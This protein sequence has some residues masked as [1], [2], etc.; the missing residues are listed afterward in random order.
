VSTTDRPAEPDLDRPIKAV[1]VRHPGR[2]V[3]ALAL[4]V[5]VAML[6]NTLVSKIPSETGPGVQWR[7]GWD[8]VGRLLF[9]APY[10]SGAEMTIWL[11]FVAMSVGIAGGL[12]VAVM[13]LSPNPLLKGSAWTFT[14]FFRGTPVVIQIFFWYNIVSVYP[15][16]AIGIP[17]GHEFWQLNPNNVITPFIAAAVLGLGI[18][19]AAYMSEIYRA[20]IL[21]V[22]AGQVEAAQSLGMRRALLMRRVVLPQALRVIIPP[23][24]NEVISMLKTTSLV[25]FVGIAELL[26]Q[27]QATIAATYQVI[28]PYIAVS[29]WYLAM[30]TVLSIGQYFLE[31]HYRR[32]TTGD[33]PD[34]LARLWARMVTK[35][36]VEVFSTQGDLDALT[37]TI[38][39]HG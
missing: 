28:P 12:L 35:R 8:E 10:V 9:S 31:R 13:R 17:F 18:N 26:Y 1:P 34:G 25:A 23:T 29:L 20:G 37:P 32:G 11:T 16:L 5:I 30:T 6:V 7:F 33:R 38:G 3:A 21:S 36:R 15:Q 19:E 2:W 22:H 24:G 14:W 4:C 39:R 27:A